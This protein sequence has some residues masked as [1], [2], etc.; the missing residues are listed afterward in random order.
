MTEM[1]QIMNLVPEFSAV[2]ANESRT[3]GVVASFTA[4]NVVSDDERLPVRLSAVLD[5]SGSMAGQKLDLV[6]ATTQ[7]MVQQLTPA[8]S[9][10][11]VCYDT[12]VEETLAFRQVSAD[13][14]TEAHNLVEK[15]RDGSCTNLSGGLFRG[16]EQILSAAKAPTPEGLE[17][18]PVDAV[19]LFTDGQ[20]NVGITEPAAICK[21]LQTVLQPT[22]KKI[23]IHTFG[24]G[25]D[26]SPTL[27]KQVA[28]VS[29][30]DYYYIRSE[31]EI[32]TAFAEALGG[33]L[34]VAA[35]N[36][37]ITFSAAHP[38]VA[39]ENVH[40]AF[41]TTQLPSGDYKVTIGDLYSEERKDLLL[42]IRLP[43]QPNAPSTPTPLLTMTAKYMDV[44]KGTFA[45]LTRTLALPRPEV[46]EEES[47]NPEVLTQRQRW[48]TTQAM[49]EAMQMAER[50]NL[51]GAQQ[52]LKLASTALEAAAPAPATS[53]MLADLRNLQFN[54]STQAAYTSRGNKSATSMVQAYAKQRSCNSQ[55][56]TAAPM[57]AA[58]SRMAFDSMDYVSR[59]VQAK[60]ASRAANNAAAP[61]LPV[62][63]TMPMPTQM[64]NMV[65]APMGL[66]VQ[67][68][69]PMAAPAMPNVMMPNVMPNVLANAQGSDSASGQWEVLGQLQQ[70]W[71]PVQMQSPF[72]VPTPPGQQG[73][74]QS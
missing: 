22:G 33:L 21:M 65:S 73:D 30:G 40:T 63:T 8:D 52:V 16:V 64:A 49:Q 9:L 61:F 70:A 12:E 74:A 26:H 50:G 31:E 72:P 59:T 20:A 43:P 15:I 35:Q 19:F 56:K 66:P 24:F 23:K 71:P 57:N 17:K 39:I 13:V 54:C 6:K 5:K 67:R 18:W 68:T 37:E 36:L 55:S 69:M 10:G 32:P 53:A 60:A 58:S 1:N 4:T 3:I 44:T 45:T 51:L 29:G 41:P 62:Q 34:S 11:I 38:G 7:F 42:S 47:P 48:Q 27:L 25:E 28:D 46:A 2:A 14:K